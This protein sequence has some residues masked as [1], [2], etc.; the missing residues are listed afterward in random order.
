[1]R[2]F[3]I[4]CRELNDSTWVWK[5]NTFTFRTA[6]SMRLWIVLVEKLGT[7]GLY[8]NHHWNCIN[9]GPT[10]ICLDLVKI[11]W[12]LPVYNVRCCSCSW[13]CYLFAWLLHSLIF[14]YQVIASH[15]LCSK[16][17][18]HK[19]KWDPTDIFLVCLLHTINF[20]QLKFGHRSCA[21]SANSVDT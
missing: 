4:I 21:G 14:V 15:C 3:L 5:H 10:T 13:R 17:R 7:P 20:N 1:M 9:S 16:T 12:V 8:D 11:C 19:T 6:F 2:S 18:V